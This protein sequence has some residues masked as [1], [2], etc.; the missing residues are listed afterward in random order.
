MACRSST[1]GRSMFRDG[2]DEMIAYVVTEGQSDVDLLKALLPA[3]LCH[4]A[5]FA[6]AGGTSAVISL[7][8][9]L[10][11]VRETP[12]AIVV[13]AKSIDPSAVRERRRDVE[14]MIRSVSPGIPFKVIVA[15]PAVEGILF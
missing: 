3:D 11:A 7:A 13:D 6:A 10:I 1:S 2:V 5:W 9:S 12:V 4:G 14:D 8:S 15:V